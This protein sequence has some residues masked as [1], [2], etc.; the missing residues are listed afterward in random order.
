MKQ[1]IITSLLKQQET[2]FSDVEVSYDVPYFT[3]NGSATQT[4][5]SSPTTTASTTSTT[6]TSSTFQ[7]RTY[8]LKPLRTTT[9]LPTSENPL[10]RFYPQGGSKEEPEEQVVIHLPRIITWPVKSFL[11]LLTK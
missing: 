1:N 3:K 6:F 10:L 11:T 2:V 4:T 8:P 5:T 7:T 9:P